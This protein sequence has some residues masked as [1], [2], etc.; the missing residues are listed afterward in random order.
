MQGDSPGR[1]PEGR[2]FLPVL[3]A[4]HVVAASVMVLVLS[5]VGAVLFAPADPDIRFALLAVLAVG[6]AMVDLRAARRRGMAYGLRRQTPKS[7]GHDP[8][9]PWWVTPT[10]WGADTGLIWTTF[11]VSSTSWALLAA[12]LLGLAPPWA[13]AVYGVAF[14]VPLS[15]SALTGIGARVGQVGCRLTR[16]STQVAQVAGAL[17][18]LAPAVVALGA[19]A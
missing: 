16:V 13:G 12:A 19:G 6:G 4:A 11:R 10:V 7:V 2:R 8:R 1:S 17:V 18:L 14:A 5:Q 15:V 9:R 3:V